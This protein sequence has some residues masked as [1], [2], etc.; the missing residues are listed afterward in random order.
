MRPALAHTTRS[1]FAWAI[2]I[3]FAALVAA[4]A[5]SRGTAATVL[6]YTIG[7]YPHTGAVD[8]LQGDQWGY[9]ILY[10]VSSKR[11]FDANYRNWNDAHWSY[12]P[13]T[14]GRVIYTDGV[15]NWTHTVTST[16]ATHPHVHLGPSGGGRKSVCSNPF[17]YNATN[18]FL[19]Q[20]TEPS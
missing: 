18:R 19:C 8:C 15:G 16:D 3:G 4:I 1:P 13:W 7:G 12:P 17:D 10:P 14:Y 20:T 9:C 11:T 5:I 2:A 6:T